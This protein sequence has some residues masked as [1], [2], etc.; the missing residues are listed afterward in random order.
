MVNNNI[1]FYYGGC[2]GKVK[3]E[4]NYICTYMEIQARE[5]EVNI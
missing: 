5:F 2:F 4:Y 3:V 1:H